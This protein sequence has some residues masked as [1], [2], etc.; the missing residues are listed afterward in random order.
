MPLRKSLEQNFHL[1]LVFALALF[2]RVIFL[3][4]LPIGMTHDELNYIVTA[5][6]LFLSGSSVP[7]TAMSLFSWGTANFDVVIA[8][9]PSV[10]ISPIIG[11]FPFSQF[12][13]RFPYAIISALFVVVFYLVVQ[14]LVGTKPALVSAVVMAINPWNI[15]FGRTAFE[16]NFSLLFYF[17]AIFVVLRNNANK[18]HWALPFF[19]AGFLSYLG[20]KLL[21]LPI[22]IVTLAYKYVSEGRKRTERKHYLRFLLIAV[23]VFLLYF[24]T[25]VY[26][27]A[28]SRKS[29]L[30][31][32]DRHFSAGLVNDERRSSIN[33]PF[34]AIFSNKLSASLKYAVNNYLGAFSTNFLFING[35]QRGAYSFWQHGPFYSL[36]FL[37]I[38]AGLLFLYVNKRKVFAFVVSIVMISPVVSAVDIVETSYV[39]RAFPMFPMIVLL[40]GYGLYCLYQ[41]IGKKV[42][43][44]LIVVIYILFFLNFAYLYVFRYPVYAAEGWFF[45]EKILSN[46]L[47]RTMNKPEVSSV[48]VVVDE[49]KIVFEE[50]LFH[51]DVYSNKERIVEINSRIAN[52]NFSFGKLS[53]SAECPSQL[54]EDGVLILSSDIECDF[55]SGLSSKILSLSDAGVVFQ[56]KNDT[57]CSGYSQPNYYRL[58]ALADLKM[59]SLTDQNF[60]NLWIAK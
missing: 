54:A 40:S 8:E 35:E 57:L 32:F 21:F 46:Y 34:Q 60:C 29:E 14:R 20:A 19:L 7:L 36:D 28:G 5:K 52:S 2:L 13:A 15:H 58:N 23:F 43:R 51:S 37:L 6:S 45:S 59:E 3:D 9:L 10:L 53:F 41:M 24:A 47:E 27:P 11:V 38:L 56:I 31:F 39:I 26:Q 18:I 55:E 42:F 12:I 30:I 17:I 1:I 49:P 33:N 50:Y 22:I 4:V 44:I 48:K 16:M 25:L